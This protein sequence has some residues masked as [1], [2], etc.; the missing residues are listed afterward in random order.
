LEL[1]HSSADCLC[2]KRIW[3][4]FWGS[5][6]D[7]AGIS[8]G[9][10]VWFAAGVSFGVTV[11]FAAGVS[12][13]VTVWFVDWASAGD[14]ASAATE[15]AASVRVSIVLLQWIGSPEP[16]VFDDASV[17]RPTSARLRRSDHEESLISTALREP[18]G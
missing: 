3:V 12:F 10:T 17:T 6:V 8:F 2:R 18:D 4:W 15:A 5:D 11:W 16:A 13:G 9:V 1:R 14:R 7:A